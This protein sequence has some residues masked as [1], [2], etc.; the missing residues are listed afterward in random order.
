VGGEHRALADS[1]GVTPEAADRL[2][3]YLDLLAAWNER[4][5]LT[6]ARTPA[7]RFDLLVRPIAPAAPRLAP[8]T[9]LD[10]G[11]G[12]GSPGLVLAALRPD[13]RATLL[14]PRTRRWAFLREAARA[15]GVSAEVLRCRHDGYPGPPA[16]TVTVRALRLPVAQLVPLVAPGGRLLV[17]G[18][19][20]QDHPAL[21]REP[22]S[23]GAHSFIRS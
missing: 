5:N 8:G 10:I 17:F 18:T 15:I 22:G 14:E 3:R 23:E 2:A 16:D 13:I 20:P 12:N 19:A 21:H 11:S 7:A 9:L 4:V 1:L 6:A